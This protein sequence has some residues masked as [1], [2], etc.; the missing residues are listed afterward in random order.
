[1]YIN[2]VQFNNLLNEIKN[3]L[4]NLENN[5]LN[6]YQKIN[7]SIDDWND[8]TSVGFFQKINQEK[9]Y[10]QNMLQE[11]K[12]IIKLMDYIKEKYKPQGLKIDC[13]LK[14][15]SPIIIKLYNYENELH[16]ALIYFDN[17]DY[18]N[19]DSRKSLLLQKRALLNN[20]FTTFQSYK[21][22]LINFYQNIELEES[23]IKEKLLSINIEDINDIELEVETNNKNMYLEI[24][25]IDLLIKESDLYRKE[26][27]I[28][29]E[30]IINLLNEIK[31]FYSSLSNDL[32]TSIIEKVTF[33][34]QK[35]SSMRSENSAILVTNKEKYQKLVTETTTDFKNIVR[36][37]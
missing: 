6:Y 15:K 26:I 33:K 25:K 4:T 29:T 36:G 13:D 24:E 11:L 17:I 31:T 1:M 2:I 10:T 14:N 7:F 3:Q 19:I 30:K 21:N 16:Q 20:I 32:I 9:K 35:L 34:T 5:C 22:N 27:D 8:N 37:E 23:D 28:S 18:Q 12:K